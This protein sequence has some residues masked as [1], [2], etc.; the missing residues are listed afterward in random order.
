MSFG[1]TPSTRTGT[2]VDVDDMNCHN[3]DVAGD[4]SSY[5]D[6]TMI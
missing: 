4:Q 2:D 5:D 3:V 6:M 1:P